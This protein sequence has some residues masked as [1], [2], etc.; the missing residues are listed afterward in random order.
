MKARS[1]DIERE[2]KKK[3]VIN[4]ITQRNKTVNW[5]T[6]FSD[7]LT[8]VRKRKG[9]QIRFYIFEA[10]SNPNH[11]INFYNYIMTVSAGE[12]GAG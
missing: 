5:K 8:R 12:T 4:G 2:R 1:T 9:K 11:N 6:K 7:E 3:A 10:I